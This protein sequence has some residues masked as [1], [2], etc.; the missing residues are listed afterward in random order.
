MKTWPGIYFIFNYIVSKIYPL[1]KIVELIFLSI[2]LL[3]FVS[4]GKHTNQN[5]LEKMNLKAD[6]ILLKD[7]DDEYYF[8]D[9]NGFITKSYSSYEKFKSISNYYYI[10]NKLSKIVTISRDIDG[11]GEKLYTYYYDDNGLLQYNI[12]NGKKGNEIEYIRTTYYYIEN[13]LVKDSTF[14][15]VGNSLNYFIA[16]IQINNYDYKENNVHTEKI[17]SK[18]FF[19]KQEFDQ[20]KKDYSFSNSIYSDGLE[21]ERENSDDKIKFEYS[22]DQIGNWLTKKSVGAKNEFTSTRVIYYIGDDVTTYEQTFNAIKD[23]ILGTN[24]SI[25]KNTHENIQEQTSGKSEGSNN[26]VASQTYNS[27]QLEEKR[28]CSSCNGKGQCPKCSKPQRVRF[29]QGESPH[30]HNEIRLGMIVCKQCG[31]NLMNFGADKNESCYLCKASGWL[32]CPEC[33]SNGN[34]SYLGKCQRCKGTGFDN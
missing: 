17:K 12:L 10:N 27:N 16:H 23:A 29:K 22:K 4:C 3:S 25:G 14:E 1:K 32:Y 31:G 20:Y 18:Y 9:D 6:V 19:S 2:L 13:K 21:L 33:N 34:G 15:T 7:I 11:T 24:Q 28:K 5:D 26:L 30:D 8:F